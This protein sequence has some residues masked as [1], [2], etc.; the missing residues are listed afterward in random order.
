MN[1]DLEPIVLEESDTKIDHQCTGR[2]CM[3]KITM[4]QQMILNE[5]W[6]AV[7]SAWKNNSS[8]V[9]LEP[10]SKLRN[11]IISI[12]EKYNQGGEIL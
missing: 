3:M 2:H 5:V 4:K 11:T 9:G 6:E 12:F 7:K 10:P 8:I 1:E